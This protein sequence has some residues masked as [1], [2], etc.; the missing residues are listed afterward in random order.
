MFFGE[1]DSIIVARPTLRLL[2]HKAPGIALARAVESGERSRRGYKERSCLM[3]QIESGC[4]F[5]AALRFLHI[6]S[7]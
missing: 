1:L 6:V 7:K 2:G 4:S 3:I 5:N